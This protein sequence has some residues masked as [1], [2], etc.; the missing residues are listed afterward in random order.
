MTDVALRHTN[1]GGEIVAA[2]GLL[3]MDDGLY[4]AV[5]LSMYGGNVEDSGSD[6]DKANQWWGN[7]SEL[8]PEQ[9]YRS[10]T[11][12]ALRSLPLVPA[13]LRQIEDAVKRDLEWMVPKPASAVDVRATM[14]ALNTIKIEVAITIDGRVF[15]FEF[16]E[17]GT[18]PAAAWTA[19]QC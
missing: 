6:G 5:Y 15:R 19:L 12:H 11:Q 18:K 3:D 13:S 9:T 4:G 14:P 17:Y 2:N 7:M 1:D 8:E 16:T 10:E